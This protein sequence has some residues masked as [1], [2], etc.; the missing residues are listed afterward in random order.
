M[1]NE[2]SAIE[3]WGKLPVWTWVQF[4]FGDWK[5]QLTYGEAKS[6]G[7]DGHIYLDIALLKDLK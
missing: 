5:E 2:Q 4:E 6:L 1:S 7:N 3:K